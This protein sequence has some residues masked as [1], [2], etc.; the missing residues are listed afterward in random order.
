MTKRAVVTGASSGIGAATAARLSRQGFDVVI[1]ARRMD[2]LQDVAASIGATAL[3][4][5]V[6]DTSSV[7]GF[8][9]AVGACNVLVNNAGGALGLEPVAEADEEQWRWM[10]DANVLGVMR[11]T[12]ALLPRLIESGDGHIVNVGSIAGIEV[13]DG[14]GGYTA[15]KHALTAITQT[16]RLELVGQ[17][18]RVTEVD[19]GLVETEFSLVRFGGDAERAKTPYVGMTP[20]TAD[21]VADC[22]EWAVTRPSHVNIDQIVVKPTAQATAQRVHRARPDPEATSR[23]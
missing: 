15:A 22:I 20:L 7:A 1:G 12:R 8:A 13:Y 4:L 6:T 11:V 2:R 9:E 17:P 10:Y 19:P 21:D 5:D 18:V 23:T 14:G 16:L 3:P